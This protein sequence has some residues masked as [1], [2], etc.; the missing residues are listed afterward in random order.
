M[1]EKKCLVCGHEWYSRL[2]TPK[3]CPSCKSY[4][5]AAGKGITTGFPCT[6]AKC[7]H[8]WNARTDSPKQCPKC[9]TYLWCE[10]PERGEII[11]YDCL[12]QGREEVWVG[13]R[14]CCY[15]CMGKNF[16]PRKE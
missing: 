6:C 16:G 14:D 9:H 13:D 2:A 11:C 3:A 5:W 7:N 1:S 8:T 15:Y 12:A 10:E 4:R